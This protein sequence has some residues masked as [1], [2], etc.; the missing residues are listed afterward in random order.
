MEIRALLITKCLGEEILRLKAIVTPEGKED[1]LSGF[2]G[3]Q[4]WNCVIEIKMPAKKNL[5]CLNE[6]GL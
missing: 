4:V 3:H 1:T 5:R 2:H 6:M